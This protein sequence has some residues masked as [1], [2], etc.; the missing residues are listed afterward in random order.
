V[1]GIRR[2]RSVLGKVLENLEN[3]EERIAVLMKILRR[4]FPR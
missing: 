2:F 4:G 3:L 1:V